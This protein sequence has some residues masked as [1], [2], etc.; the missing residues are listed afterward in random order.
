MRRVGGVV[1]DGVDADDKVTAMP[2]VSESSTEADVAELFLGAP[3]AELDEANPE[4]RFRPEWIESVSA[5]LDEVIAGGAKAL[6]ITATG[7]FF[8][9][10]LDTDYIA[11]DPSALPSYL[12]DV[13]A[14]YRKVLTLPVPTVAAVNGHAFGAGAMLSLCADLVVMRTER[15]FWSLPEAALN[16]P[17]TRGMAALVRTRLPERTASEAMLTSRRYGADDAVAAG[18]VDEA[19]AVDDLLGR[20]VA[21]G[22]ERAPLAGSN[23]A[24]IKRGLRL[25][26]LDDLAVPTPASLL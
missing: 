7:K 3:G 14:L 12:D 9:N 2:F 15:G 10:G 6:V 18:I 17:F 8:T 4:N 16:M 23:Q 22:R 26:L 21:L 11:A 24:L 1:G 20:A 13:H 19:V 5:L 25:P